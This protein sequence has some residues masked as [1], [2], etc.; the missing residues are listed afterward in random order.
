MDPA[1]QKLVK[2]SPI[3]L[4]ICSCA[5]CVALADEAP[6][7]IFFLS[8]ESRKRFMEL[9]EYL[10]TLQINFT[11]DETLIGPVHYSAETVYEIRDKDGNVL[12]GGARHDQLVYRMGFRR[13]L[14]FVEMTCHYNKDKCKKVSKKVSKDIENPNIYY[15]HLGYEAKLRSLPLIEKL[16]GHGITVRHFLTEQ[17]CRSQVALAEK[18]RPKYILIMGIKEALENSI[19]IRDME[20]HS[21]QTIP[22][23]ELSRKARKLKINVK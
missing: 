15:V 14:P 17:K 1:C 21:Q 8:E 9:I 10:E 20:K 5:K 2:K 18:A 19:L 4:F 16:R 3:A 7:P 22:L 13:E 12:G 23:G 11:V 6:K